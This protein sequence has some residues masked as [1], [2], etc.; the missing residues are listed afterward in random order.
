MTPNDKLFEDITE[1][2]LQILRV[3]AT[4]RKEVLTEL[5]RLE[6]EIVSKL[7]EAD[8]F[9]QKRLRALLSDVRKSISD[10]YFV[11]TKIMSDNLT[12]LAS[13]EVASTIKSINIQLA[14]VPL[15]KVIQAIKSSLINGAP[16]ESWWKRQSEHLKERFEDEVRTG[17]LLGETNQQILR[18]V[19][20]TRDFNFTNGILNASRRDAENLVRSSVQAAANQA[21]LS[22]FE[23]NHDLIQS[24]RH[25]STLDSR[26]SDVCIVR[27]GKRWTANDKKPIGHNL[28]FMRPPIHW[29]CRSTLI[30]ELKGVKLSDD[31]TR[32]SAD[33]PVSANTT[34]ESFLKRK[35]DSFADE[36]L[37]PGKAKL[38]RDGTI[39]LR[40]LL[41]QSGNP[42]TLKELR[43]KYT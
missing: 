4:M 28:P 16:S 9:T 36:V 37:G 14:T 35:G 3:D 38:Y 41:D 42:L 1:R 24:Y 11:I 31:A 30:A 33:G 6:Q 27:D 17:I 32:A 29:N 7:T 13:I 15:Q 5:K 43:Q 18:R 40:Q 22:V 20:G 25:V 34:F 26:T 12:E 23:E 21:R 10:V 2:Q 39:S 8:T 19:R